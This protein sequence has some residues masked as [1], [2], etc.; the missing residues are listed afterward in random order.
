M[1][2]HFKIRL[3][4]KYWF[5]FTNLWWLRIKFQDGFFLILV[6]FHFSCNFSALIWWENI[7]LA[8]NSTVTLFGILSFTMPTMTESKWFKLKTLGNNRYFKRAC[9]MAK[10]YSVGCQSSAFKNE[11]SP[12]LPNCSSR[13]KLHEAQVCACV[14]NVYIK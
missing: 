11:Y 2:T 3:N 9:M 8:H 6:L 12:K 14:K 5:Q 13:K 7:W 4:S 1:F 10:V